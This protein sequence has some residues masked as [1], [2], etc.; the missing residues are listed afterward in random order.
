MGMDDTLY[1]EGVPKKL[2]PG[3]YVRRVNGK[4]LTNEDMKLI[5]VMKI[6]YYILLQVIY[7][8]RK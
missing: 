3:L 2:Q 7:D 1:M 8:L 5:E 4:S 6:M